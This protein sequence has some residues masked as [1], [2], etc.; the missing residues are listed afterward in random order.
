MR[1]P[2]SAH[3]TEGKQIAFARLVGDAA[4]RERFAADPAREAAALVDLPV[5]AI[6]GYAR[7]L[8]QKRAHETRRSLPQSARAPDFYDRFMRYAERRPI[9]G[10]D[11]HRLD[12]IAFARTLGT[13]TAA[14]ER[15]E[16]EALAGEPIVR[17]V[18]ERGRLDWWFRVRR[19]AALRRGSLRIAPW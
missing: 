16:L 2:A 18:I 14:R 8:L 7:G 11:R 4:A 9:G 1:E 3:L 12:A 15:Y 5:R 6:D 19:G 13:R 17:F 10:I